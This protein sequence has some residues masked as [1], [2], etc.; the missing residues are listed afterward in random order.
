MKMKITAKPWI[1]LPIVL[2]AACAAPPSPAIPA[3]IFTPVLN[4][5]IAAPNG[6]RPLQKGDEIEG[7]QIAYQYVLPS[8]DQPV[9]DIAFGVDLLDLL[10]VKPALTDSLV[11]YAKEL[12]QQPHNIVGFDENDPNQTAPKPLTT[13]ANK[14]LEVAF[15]FLTEGNH[16]WSVTETDNGEVRTAYKLVRRKDGGLRFIDAYDTITEHS[17]AFP[18]INGGG[19]GLVYSS[20][21]ALLK[22]I[23]ADSAYQRGANVIASKPP[24]LDKYDSRIL[25]TDPTQQGLAQDLDWVLVSRPGPNPGLISP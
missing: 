12:T 3:P 6:Y 9:V 7:T 10:S 5:T 19:A 16:N 24:A 13:D 4:P 22:L 11:S 23:L 1:V 25:K 14:P 2:L 20:R 8:V 17:I 21:L 15:I 18:T